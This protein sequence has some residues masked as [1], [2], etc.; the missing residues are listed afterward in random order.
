LGKISVDGSILR[1]KDKLN[2]REWR[3][4]S[5]HPEIGARIVKQIGFL[6]NIS[7][8][9]LYHHL[10][11]CGGGYPKTN[12]SRSRIPIGARILAVA[13]AYEAMLSDRPYRSALTEREAA[14]RLKIQR[15]KQ[16]DPKV[17][18][19]FLRILERE[20]R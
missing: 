5:R 17:V 1:K 7:P 20:K 6:N 10:K 9:I 4:V 12:L 13:D 3:E 18:N 16:F 2:T 19:T 14:R 15:G 8:I 11:Y